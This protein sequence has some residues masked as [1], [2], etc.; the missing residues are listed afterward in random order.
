MVVGFAAETGDERG[1]A[2]D[3]AKDKLARKGCD[4][5]VLNRVDDGR[6][7]EV[8]DNAGVLLSADGSAPMQ[9]PFGPKTVLASVICGAISAGLR[10]AGE[11][12][13]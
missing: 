12:P 4:L 6:A 8:T 7:F 3:Y 11:R 9:I 13:G 10:A 5:L 2:L 1:S